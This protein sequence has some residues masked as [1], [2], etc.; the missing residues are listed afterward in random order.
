MVGSHKDQRLVGVLVVEV[1]GSLHG[2]VE[3]K[4][5]MDGG[6][7]VIGMAGPVDLAALGHHEE[8]LLVAQTLDALLDVVSEAPLAL[9]S[10]EL[11]V[12]GVT[13]GQGLGDDEAVAGIGAQGLRISLRGDHGVAGLCG[14]L[15][16]VGLVLVLVGG[17]KPCTAGEELKAGL[18]HFLADCVVVLAAV[19]VSVESSRGGMVHVDRGK[20]ADLV[21]LLGVQ[22]LGDGLKRLG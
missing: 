4:H 17:S 5:V 1:D 3:G 16:E 22:L 7:S 13:V 9:G 11:V 6:G 20:H 12:H 18:G 2:G 10:V 14:E 15:V 8:G 21:A 19:L